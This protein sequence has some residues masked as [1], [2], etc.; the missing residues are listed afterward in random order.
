MK[1]LLRIQKVPG[2]RGQAIV[3]FSLVLMILLVVMVGILEVGRL[4]FMY[5]AVNNAS[6]EAARYASA[7]GLD[8]N[9]DTGVTAEKYRFCEMIEKMAKRSAFFTTPAVNISYDHGPGTTA[10]DTCNG[11]VDTG[12]SINSGTNVDRVYVTVSA[13]YSPMLSLIPIGSR[14]FTSTSA[15]TILGFQDLETLSTSTPIPT[16]PG[17]PTT[18]GTVVPSNTPTATATATVASQTPTATLIG[19]VVTMTP[20]PSST[21]SLVP[22]LTHTATVTLTPTE[23]VTPTLTFTPTVTSTAV[24]GCNSISTGSI[25]FDTK[26][27]YLFITNPHD[28]I[29]VLNVQVVW[30]ATTGAPSSSPLSLRSAS[31]NGVFWAGTDST[32]NLTITPSTTV[33]IPGNNQTSKIVFTFDKN[34]QTR[35]NTESIV[36]NLATSGCENYTIRKP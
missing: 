7:I 22:T 17:V 4:M 13:D 20:L 2:A 6:R 21:P 5:A 29:T 25:I 36:I 10:F 27:M 26:T 28:S 1:I 3:E 35:N 24:P 19:E 8:T 9:P 14:T 30:N 23:T 11:S 12:L 18:P 34:Y 31:L 16:T 32:G 33:T 15:R